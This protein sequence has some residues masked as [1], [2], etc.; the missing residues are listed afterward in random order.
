MEET[1]RNIPAFTVLVLKYTQNVKLFTNSL[2]SEWKI[3]FQDTSVKMANLTFEETFYVNM[4][5]YAICGKNKHPS[6]YKVMEPVVLQME[7]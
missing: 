6:K 1:Q 2:Q 7:L 4:L 3:Y 5:R